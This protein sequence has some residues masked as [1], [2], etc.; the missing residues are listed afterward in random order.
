[1][2]PIPDPNSNFF[3]PPARAR[4]SAFSLVEVTIAMAIVSVGGL[5]LL[6]TLE[7]ATRDSRRIRMHDETHRIEDVIRVEISRMSF[8][9][10]YQLLAEPDSPTY[11]YTYRGDPE[12]V[13][14]DLTPEPTDEP[15]WRMTNGFRRHED[16]PL[17]ED[18]AAAEDTVFKVR[19]TPFLED[20]RIQ[21]ALPGDAADYES[22]H[23]RFFVE[24][25]EDPAPGENPMTWPDSRRLLSF[26]MSISR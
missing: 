3:A 2:R 10:V 17:S 15:G 13:R 7:Q 11:A 5:T 19:L 25:F 4:S 18:L 12:A 22:P 8:P 16:E 6:A 21:V 9:D 20:T 23:L 26:P 24:V 1:M 14:D